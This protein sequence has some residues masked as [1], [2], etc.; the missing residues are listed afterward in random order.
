MEKVKPQHTVHTAATASQAWRV[1][2]A[3][4]TN[5]LMACRACHAETGRYCAAGVDLRQSYNNTQMETSE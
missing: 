2:A 5:H 3:A 1:A 4:Y